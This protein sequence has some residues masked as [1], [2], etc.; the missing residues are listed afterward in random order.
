MGSKKALGRRYK[1][2]FREY[3]DKGMARNSKDFV[4]VAKAV[5]GRK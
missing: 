3:S 5:V 4:N 1:L 2:I